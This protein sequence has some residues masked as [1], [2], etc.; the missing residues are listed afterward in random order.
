MADL[1]KVVACL[2]KIKGKNMGQNE[3]N[4][5]HFLMKDYV[6]QNEDAKKL[7]EEALLAKIIKSVIFNGKVAYRIVRADPVNDSLFV[8]ETQ[9]SEC[10]NEDDNSNTQI[11]EDTLVV[12]DHQGNTGLVSEQNDNI[13]T[14]LE[15]FRSSL[16]AIENRFLKIE[17]HLIGL[18]SNSATTLNRKDNEMFENFYFDLLKK[19]ISELEKQ[20]SE[21]NA[22]IDF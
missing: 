22:I 18:S 3:D 5:L 13:A 15:N 17:D 9:E 19:R 8:Q 14:V 11:V 4:L 7:I 21:K 16:E 12:S 20:L 2:E 10:N 1:N 6:I